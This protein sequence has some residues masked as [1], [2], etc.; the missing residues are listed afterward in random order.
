MFN[1]NTTILLKKLPKINESG[2]N[3][4]SLYIDE[5]WNLGYFGG[6]YE[7]VSGVEISVTSRWT[8]GAREKSIESFSDTE[9]C[10]H[11]I[12]CF[13]KSFAIICEE[14]F[15]D[16]QKFSHFIRNVEKCICVI[17]EANSFSL[18]VKCREKAAW[19]TE[20]F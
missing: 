2:D 3:A 4:G 11:F 16:L 8:I 12:S 6:C 15:L 9:K 14:N 7:E 1:I 5:T 13:F 18:F 10:S 20:L 17:Q 19:F